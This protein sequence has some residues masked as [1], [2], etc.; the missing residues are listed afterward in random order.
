MVPSAAQV[1]SSAPSLTSTSVVPYFVYYGSYKVL[2]AEKRAAR[3]LGPFGTVLDAAATV[4][5]PTEAAGLAGDVAIDVA[6]GESV[7]DEGPVDAHHRKR[8]I[9][10]LHSFVPK[11]LRGPQWYLPGVHRSGKIDWRW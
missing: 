11:S 9:N 3:R 8:Y 4:F 2:G 6:K 5:V 7:R 1:T 10:P